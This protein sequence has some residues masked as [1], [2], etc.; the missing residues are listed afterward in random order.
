MEVEENG[1]KEVKQVKELLKVALKPGENGGEERS[2]EKEEKIKEEV[3][4]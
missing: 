4:G 1:R 2:G 3:K